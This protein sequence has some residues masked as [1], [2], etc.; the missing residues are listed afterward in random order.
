MLENRIHWSIILPVWLEP[1]RRQVKYLV[2]IIDNTNVIMLDTFERNLHQ[3][4]T[5]ISTS[6]SRRVKFPACR[7]SSILFIG[8]QIRAQYDVAIQAIFL[9]WNGGFGKMTELVQRILEEMEQ[10]ENGDQKGR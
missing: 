8:S 2:L 3:S 5:I 10:E 9:L 7:F 1:T 4:Y 6:L